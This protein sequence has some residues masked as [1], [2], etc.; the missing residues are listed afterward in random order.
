MSP[1]LEVDA[2]IALVC[3]VTVASVVSHNVDKDGPCSIPQDTQEAALVKLIV[4]LSREPA[5]AFFW[6]RRAGV[7]LVV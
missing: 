1:C 5:W 2:G 6:R 7:V 4:E 3:N